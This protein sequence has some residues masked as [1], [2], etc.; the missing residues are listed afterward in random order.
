MKTEAAAG[1]LR[2][3]FLPDDHVLS[4]DAERLVKEHGDQADVVAAQLADASFRSGDEVTGFRW[5]K[6]FRL[7]A[8]S[9]IHRERQRLGRLSDRLLDG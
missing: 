4:V 5:I 9:H 6:I 3:N 2:G 1:R 7:I 8:A